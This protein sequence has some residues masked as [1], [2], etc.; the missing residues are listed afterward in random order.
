[1]S[2]MYIPEKSLQDAIC[3]VYLVVNNLS[4]VKK[5]DEF[6]KDLLKEKKKLTP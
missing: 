1:M 4:Q 5:M 6:L 3:E 2:R